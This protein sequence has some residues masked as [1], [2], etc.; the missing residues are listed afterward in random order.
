[1]IC[2]TRLDQWSR[3]MCLALCSRNSHEKFNLFYNSSPRL[4]CVYFC[5]KG[6]HNSCKYVPNVNG[7]G[8]W[9]T[10]T[11]ASIV[12]DSFLKIDFNSFIVFHC[13][14]QPQ[15]LFILSDPTLD[16]DWF[17]SG[18]WEGGILLLTQTRKQLENR[19]GFRF[20]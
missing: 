3:Y 18:T 12:F 20:E 4:I 15:S 8:D 14:N 10:R 11:K 16:L 5:A 1:M 2:S 13:F 17:V 6:A 19:M 7:F 9:L